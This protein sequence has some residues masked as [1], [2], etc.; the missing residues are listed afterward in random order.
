M[1][2]GP[3]AG[4]DEGHLLHHRPGV[5]PSRNGHSASAAARWKTFILISQENGHEHS[6]TLPAHARPHRTSLDPCAAG[7]LPPCCSSLCAHELH[8]LRA[9]SRDMRFRSSSVTSAILFRRL[10]T[11][12]YDPPQYSAATAAEAGTS[13]GAESL[14]LDILLQKFISKQNL[15]S[16][17]VTT[18]PPVK[19]LRFASQR[20]RPVKAL[21]ADL[22]PWLNS[23]IGTRLAERQHHHAG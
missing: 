12:C 6:S 15:G 8:I 2:E 21:G 22:G 10:V 18:P 11:R 1:G 14:S 17:I 19:P 3:T 5:V 7:V 23:S 9:A 16:K 20:S 4:Q 13:G